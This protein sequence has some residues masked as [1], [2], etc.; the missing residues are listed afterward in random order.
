MTLDQV[1]DR[2]EGV[3]KHGGGRFMAKCPS[4]QDKTASLGITEKE[5]RILLHCFGG[6]E[7]RWVL[8]GMGLEM[9]DLFADNHQGWK[10]PIKSRWSA[11]QILSG[12]GEAMS[13]VSLLLTR[14]RTQKLN[15]FELDR[16]RHFSNTIIIL[17]NEG[18]AR[19]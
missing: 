11:T 15:D 12:L 16:L 5:D 10:R 17:C 18:T 9:H 2:L 7:T 6:C 19:G 1:L 4:H 14:Q 13:E 3:K 8:G